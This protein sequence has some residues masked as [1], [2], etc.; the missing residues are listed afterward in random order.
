MPEISNSGMK[1]TEGSLKKISDTTEFSKMKTTTTEVSKGCD[2][3]T[4]YNNFRITGRLTNGNYC[5]KF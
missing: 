5:N 4:Y 3:K 1:S 2:N